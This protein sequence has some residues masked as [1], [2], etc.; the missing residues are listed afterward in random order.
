MQS[1]LVISLPFVNS[2]IMSSTVIWL[3]QW[4]A[5]VLS[6]PGFLF[7]CLVIAW[8]CF[9]LGLGAVILKGLRQIQRALI[10]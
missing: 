8:S 7:G 10:P 9:L 2:V 3:A 4:L 5:L 1:G 6:L